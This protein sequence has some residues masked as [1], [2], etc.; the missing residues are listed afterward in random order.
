MVMFQEFNNKIFK[1]LID[2]VIFLE[3]SEENIVDPDSAAELLETIGAELQSMNEKNRQFFKEK[4]KVIAHDYSDDKK[5]F[6]CSLP[7]FF[8]LC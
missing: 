1:C 6:V 3:F 7:D 2:K 4:I 5:N 8:G